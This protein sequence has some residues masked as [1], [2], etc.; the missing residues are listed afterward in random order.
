MRVETR[1]L[2]SL[3]M[4]LP[5]EERAQ[6]ARELLR[7]ASRDRPALAGEVAEQVSSYGQSLFEPFGQNPEAANQGSLFGVDAAVAA[8]KAA[9]PVLGAPPVVA[10]EV[11]MGHDPNGKPMAAVVVILEDHPKG[12]LYPWNQLAPIDDLIWEAFGAQAGIDAA[13]APWP[14]VTFRQKS[15]P[16]VL[17]AEDVAV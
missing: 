7:S 10:L 12:R 1:K 5:P 15:E 2:L 4:E 3:G 13:E 16:D 9:L 17:D 6:L 11:E 8:V 14:Y